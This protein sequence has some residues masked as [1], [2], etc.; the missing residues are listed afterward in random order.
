MLSLQSGDQPTFP[1]LV[2]QAHTGPNS[3]P[4]RRFFQE[5]MRV[6]GIPGDIQIQVLN[7][8]AGI[9]HLGNIS[10]IEA[11]NY[12]KVESTDCEWGQVT[13]VVARARSQQARL[14]SD[15]FRV[16]WLSPCRSSLHPGNRWE[17]CTTVVLSCL[18][19][20]LFAGNPPSVHTSCLCLQPFNDGGQLQ[21]FVCVFVCSRARLQP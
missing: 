7:I 8:V 10:F 16:C 17:L 1:Q 3:L 5:A 15:C 12:A 9:L 18:S 6:I 20:S 4:V 13:H 14:L 11:G 21:V 2:R 19:S